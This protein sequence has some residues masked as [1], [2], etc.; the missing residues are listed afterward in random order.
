MINGHE[1]VDLGLPSGT[2]WATCNVGAETPEE[3]GTPFAYGETK[4]KS[5]YDWENYQLVDFAEGNGRDQ[6]KRYNSRKNSGVVDN[7]EVLL[8]SDDAATMA[9]GEDWFTPT[10]EDVEELVEKCHFKYEMHDD[11]EG[12]VVTGP[13]G[14]SIYVAFN[15][16]HDSDTT[17]THYEGSFMRTSTVLR[18]DAGYCHHA[19]VFAVSRRAGLVHSYRYVGLPV[20]PVCRKKGTKH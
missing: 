15:Q 17:W 13:N 20:R 1:A 10:K 3:E 4:G 9:W 14:K 16:V 18:D 7:L 11:T 2:M 5:T 19:W 6:Y 12:Y 8:R